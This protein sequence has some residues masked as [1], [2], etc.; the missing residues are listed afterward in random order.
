M[1]LE[2][3]GKAYLPAHLLPLGAPNFDPFAECRHKPWQTYTR[4]PCSCGRE[5]WPPRGRGRGESLNSPRRVAAKQK[6]IEAM[7]LRRQ[8]YRWRV[9]AAQV[10]YA[11]PQGAHRAVQRTV[12]LSTAIRNYNEWRRAE[13][14]RPHDRRP[15]AQECERLLREIDADLRATRQMADVRIE[16][17][18]DYLARTLAGKPC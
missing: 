15:S 5:L 2:S 17:A 10:G 16:I 12:D 4:E 13:G 9:I 18:E 11:T 6:A 14:G 3:L 8:G 1:L 7:K